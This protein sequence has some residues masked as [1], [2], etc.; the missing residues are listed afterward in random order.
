[1][2][3]RIM[4]GAAPEEVLA[5]ATVAHVLRSEHHQI[6]SLVAKHAELYQQMKTAPVA[7][8]PKLALER[9][10]RSNLPLEEVPHVVDPQ[11]HLGLDSAPKVASRE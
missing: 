10:G 7:D 8:I 4:A 5:V 2:V 3:D 1:M 9:Y 6:G 11:N